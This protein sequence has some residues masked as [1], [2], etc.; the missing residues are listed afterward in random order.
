[1]QYT[2]DGYALDIATREL[3]RG[4]ALVPIAP[5]VFDLLEYLI[6]HRERVVTKD[7]LIDAIWD[8]RAVSEAAVTTRFNAAR[9]AI[10]D[11][12]NEQRLIKTLPRRGFRFVAPVHEVETPAGARA[13]ATAA[14]A[15]AHDGGD[16]TM[17]DQ[18]V[19]A[20]EAQAGDGPAPRLSI[21]VLPLTSIGGGPEQAAFADGVTE[22]LITDLSRTRNSFIVAR[23]KP[24]AHNGKAIEVRQAGREA[25]ARYVLDGSL[26]RSGNRLRVNVQ[27]ID[28]ETGRHLWADRFEKP[29]VDAFEL[30]DE[31]AWRLVHLVTIQLVLDQARR[32]R[33][34]LLPGPGDLVMQ[35]IASL[36]E[37]LTRQSVATARSFFEAALALDSGYPNAL[38]GLAAVD[39]NTCFYLLTD[40]PAAILSRA[41]ANVVKALSFAPNY[42]Y[43]HFVLGNVYALT[44]RVDQSIA[45]YEKAM[46]LDHSMTSALGCVGFVKCFIGRAA[47]AEGHILE[48]L[49]LCPHHVDAHYMKYFLGEALIYLGDDAKAVDW[50]RRSIE[51]NRNLPRAH[52]ALAAALGLLGSADEAKRA[53]Q[54]GIAINP[55]FTIRRL[56]ANTFSNNPV[57]LAGLGRFIAGL[58]LAGVPQG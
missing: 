30:Q 47:E 29:V 9:S 22:S 20:G 37:G 3:R 19:A 34:L 7:E 53:A 42:A 21:L 5:Q 14:D 24:D 15:R 2:F 6:R 41:E 35:G 27:L 54:E 38:V 51:T 50:L 1:L 18:D 16:T 43:G 10:G 58:R 33:R 23:R 28:V 55:G 26:Q 46:E 57:Y 39:V 13:M 40:E 12:G 25:N 4:A 52:F 8:G 32:A 45:A 49:R 17:S 48:A 56:Q 44:N 31:I 36:C 11:S